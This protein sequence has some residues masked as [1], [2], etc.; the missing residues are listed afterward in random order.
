MFIPLSTNTLSTPSKTSS[1]SNLSL[2]QSP[3]LHIG[4]TWLSSVNIQHASNGETS[5]NCPPP[6]KE[7]EVQF[8]LLYYVLPSLPILHHCNLDISPLCGWCGERRS[9]W[10]LFIL[11]P[12]IQPALN[13]LHCLLQC[14]LPDLQLNFDVYWALVPHTRG[15]SREAVNLVNYLIISCKMK[16]TGCAARPG[17]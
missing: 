4:T 5:S 1:S 10:H 14:L 13:L 6:K 17:L 16:F 3:P 8:K 2:F 12:E 11:C 7:G 15:R 9:I